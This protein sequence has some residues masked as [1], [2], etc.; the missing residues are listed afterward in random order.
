MTKSEYLAALQQKLSALS[1]ADIKGY[2]DYYAEMIDDRIEEGMTEKDAVDAVG[3]V[4]DAAEKILS[5]NP[6]VE[7]Q[8]PNEKE[9]EKV[10]GVVNDG[11]IRRSLVPGMDTNDSISTIMNTDFKY[12]KNICDAMKLAKTYGMVVLGSCLTAFA[13]AFVVIPQ[14]LAAGGVTGFSILLRNIIPLPI[15]VL[16]FLINLILFVLGWLVVGKD[17]VFKTLIASIVFPVALELAQHIHIFD[18]LATDALGSSLIAGAVL[19]LGSGMILN[20]KGSGGGFDVIGV[21]LNKKIGVSVSFVMYSF[22]FGIILAQTVLN[23]MLKTVYGIIVIIVAGFVVEKLVVRGK[24]AS[25]I[26]IFSNY[27]EDICKELISNLDVGMT[28]V[29]GEGGYLRKHE[30]IIM[31]VVHFDMVEKIKRSVYAIDPSAFV[32]IDTVNYVGG[33]GYTMDRS[34]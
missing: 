33:R 6:T 19:G 30:K 25:R 24:S 32:M 27:Y 14:G 26:L 29:E 4:E 5:E 16:V 34:I 12:A 15:S 10:I 21:V 13:F 3:S 7:N 2:T 20:G 28:F 1:P 23:G 22:D 8:N 9:S 11:D 17:F 31:T 18:E